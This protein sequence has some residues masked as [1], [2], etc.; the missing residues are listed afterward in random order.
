MEIEHCGENELIIK[1][2]DNNTNHR[3]V[4]RITKSILEYEFPEFEHSETHKGVIMPIA[5]F[6]CDNKWC[7]NPNGSNLPKYIDISIH[8]WNE[9]IILFQHRDCDFYDS[10]F[11]ECLFNTMQVSFLSDGEPFRYYARKKK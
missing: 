6:V 8:G 11:F 7:D 10:R 9:A 1:F 5:P 3:F 4:V 2:D